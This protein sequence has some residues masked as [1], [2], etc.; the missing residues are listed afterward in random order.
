MLRVANGLDN[1]AL[2]IEAGTTVHF[3]RVYIG[4]PKFNPQYALEEHISI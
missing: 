1:A 3:K 2:T 4:C